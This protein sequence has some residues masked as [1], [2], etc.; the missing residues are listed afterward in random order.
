MRCATMSDTLRIR[1]SWPSIF[2][3][4][5]FLALIS[6][7]ITVNQYLAGTVNQLSPLRKGLESQTDEASPRPSLAYTLV[8]YY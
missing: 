2:F 4:F 7:T 3:F 8:L 6:T 5:F 1:H